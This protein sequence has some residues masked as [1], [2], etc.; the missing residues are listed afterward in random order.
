VAVDQHLAVLGDG[1][2]HLAALAQALEQGRG[3]AVDEALGEALV[4]GVAE[5]VLDLGGA[6]LPVARVAQPVGAVRHVG[7]G[8]DVGEPRG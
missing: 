7:P 2:E 3:A 6:L 4:Q 1:R 5:P 8:A